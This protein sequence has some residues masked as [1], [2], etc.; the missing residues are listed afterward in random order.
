MA[1]RGISKTLKKSNRYSLLTGLFDA[2][3]TL[4]TRVGGEVTLD[5]K[6]M[7][8]LAKLLEGQTRLEDK[9]TRIESNMARMESGLTEKIDALFDGQKVQQDIS[10]R[11]L[12]RVEILE[13]KVEDLQ[14]Q[15]AH[16]R[17][18]K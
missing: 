2:I 11:I 8:V 10:Q 5:E 4:Q 17:V 9:V 1:F 16:I 6:I 18:V 14:L 13:T 3:L 12:E 15:T 7:E